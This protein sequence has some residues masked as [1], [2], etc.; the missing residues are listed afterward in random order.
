LVA[1]PLHSVDRLPHRVISRTVSSITV[2]SPARGML[3]IV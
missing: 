1:V 3:V 2:R